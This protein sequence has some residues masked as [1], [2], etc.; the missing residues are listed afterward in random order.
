MGRLHAIA[1]LVVPKRCAVCGGGEEIL[2]A[3]CRQLLVRARPP[4]CARCGAPTAWPVERCVEC[5]GRRLGY[6]TARAAVLYDERAKRLV[7]VWKEG[8]LSGLTEVLTS[9]VADVVACPAAHAVVFV[10]ADVDRTRWRG[11]AAP[12]ALAS[13]LA[14]RW[15]LP[16]L[17]LL[18][19]TRRPRRQR[20]LDRTAR[21]ANVRGAFAAMGRGPA[22]VVLVDDV[23]TTGATVSAAA[24]ALR[25]A[26][27]REIHV[28]TFA[29]AVRH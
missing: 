19:R 2:C 5:A 10:P 14:A 11:L 16:F 28:V 15:E 7:R 9:I 12:E 3:V 26:R 24:A 23:Y 25:R 21:R 29:R 4:L 6:A 18:V 13:R 1:D 22:S 27:V 8:G 20:G 17:P